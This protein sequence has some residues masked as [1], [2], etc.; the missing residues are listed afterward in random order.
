MPKVSSSKILEESNFSLNNLQP[1][2]YLKTFNKMLDYMQKSSVRT[3]N[4]KS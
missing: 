3:S 1:V 2:N 4:Y